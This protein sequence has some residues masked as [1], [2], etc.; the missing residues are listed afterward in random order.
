VIE[1]GQWTTPL[2]VVVALVAWSRVRLGDHSPAQVVAG[3]IAGVVLA[4][5]VYVLIA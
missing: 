4:P 3:A 2:F 5:P 1:F